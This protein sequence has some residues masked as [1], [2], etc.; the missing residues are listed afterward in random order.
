MLLNRIVFI[1]VMCYP[2]ID[3]VKELKPKVLRVPPHPR[4]VIIENH[5]SKR[6]LEIYAYSAGSDLYQQLPLGP[7]E[8]L[9]FGAKWI[10]NANDEILADAELGIQNGSVIRVVETDGVD[11]A[12]IFFLYQVFPDSDFLRNMNDEFVQGKLKECKQYKQSEPKF[13]YLCSPAILCSLKGYIQCVQTESWS[14]TEV[15]GVQ[16]DRHIRGHVKLSALPR[17]VT[18]ATI[19]NN[20][21]TSVDMSGLQ[22]HALKH[23]ILASD[24]ITKIRLENLQKSSV[25][26][27]RLHGDGFQQ[28]NLAQ[29]HGSSLRKLWIIENREVGYPGVIDLRQL[30]SMSP[31][32]Q[33]T[34]S[35]SYLAQKQIDVIVRA[36]TATS[37]DELHVE[38]TTHEIITFSW[39]RD[40]KKVKNL[41]ATMPWMLMP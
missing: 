41:S 3:A 39:K 18:Q 19:R 33:L 16:I 6:S 13:I 14:V 15:R 9:Y 28:I 24:M 32:K 35:S 8:R 31:L 5:R 38:H 34:I 26:T 2:L 37:L 12:T 17:T 20:G 40:G 27:L 10:R 11:P 1:L 29:L 25:E 30:S 4:I 36:A 23:L 7:G 22:E 21:L